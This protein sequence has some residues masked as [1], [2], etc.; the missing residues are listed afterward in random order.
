MLQLC[1][2][3]WIQEISNNL[4]MF[5]PLGS[6]HTT[7]EAMNMISRHFQVFWQCLSFGLNLTMCVFGLNCAKLRP[8]GSH[9]SRC[10]Y[11]ESTKAD[12][13]YE[14]DFKTLSSILA[15]FVFRP[16]LCNVCLQTKLCNVS[17]IAHWTA[18]TEEAVFCKAKQADRQYEFDFKTFWQCLYFGLI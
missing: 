7:A 1:H 8:L 13:Q 14:Y 4:A 16:K 11:L 12:W 9:H 15:M 2:A 18:T 3:I 10:C 6:Q 5:R 17:T